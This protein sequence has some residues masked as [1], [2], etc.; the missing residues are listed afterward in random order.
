MLVSY[1]KIGLVIALMIGSAGIAM[2]KDKDK[3]TVPN[4]GPQIEPVVIPIVAPQ[5]AKEEDSGQEIYKPTLQKDPS[6]VFTC[7]VVNIGKKPQ[8]FDIAILSSEGK[9]IETQAAATLPSGFTS[10]DSTKTK[11]TIGYCRVRVKGAAKNMLVTLCSQSSTS[12]SCKAVVT[13]QYST[14]E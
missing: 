12:S 11:N 1:K 8:F 5:S 4:L 7:R 14:G 9:P 13:G 3:E 10:S 6:E 2:A